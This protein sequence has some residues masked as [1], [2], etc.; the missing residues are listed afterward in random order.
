MLSVMAASTRKRFS[1][2]RS[3]AA[4]NRLNTNQWREH[5][6]LPETL[7]HVELIR[8]LYIIRPHACLHAVVELAD[9][10]EHS[11]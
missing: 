10:G 1:A 2:T 5:A 3:T 11:R 6:S 9:D 7:P 8:A 4:K